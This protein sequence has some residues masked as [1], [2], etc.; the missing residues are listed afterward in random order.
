V[1]ADQGLAAC[2][3]CPTCSDR[4]A[5]L[6]CSQLCLQH[7][8]LPRLNAATRCPLLQR[9]GKVGSQVE[10]TVHRTQRTAGLLVYIQVSHPWTAQ[11]NGWLTLDLRVHGS[12]SPHC[13]LQCCPHDGMGGGSQRCCALCCMRPHQH[14]SQFKPRQ[15][16]VKTAHLPNVVG[17]AYTLLA[18]MWC[19]AAA[20]SVLG[21]QLDLKAGAGNNRAAAHGFFE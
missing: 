5:A 16:G 1:S 14:Y 10:P 4:M 18:V 20:A 8:A 21:C 6:P 19:L 17:P 2:H 13:T 15:C 7:Y 11:T 3:M 9:T 12:C